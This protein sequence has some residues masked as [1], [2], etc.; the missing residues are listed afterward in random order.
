MLRPIDAVRAVLIVATLA[1]GVLVAEQ[2]QAQGLTVGAHLA[3]WHSEPGY[4]DRNPGLYAR[5]AEGWTAGA[6]CNSESRSPLFP[7]APACRVS[8]YAG[9][10]WGRAI[11][12]G[13]SADLTAGLITGY[14]RAGVLPMVVPSLR[15]GTADLALRLAAIPRIDPKRG[16]H[17]VHVMVEGRF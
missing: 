7:T 10:T 2:A 3:S 17:V 16:S 5:T 12:P 11:A 13:L 6:Y 9:R 8:A 4:N 14:E 1:A 15:I